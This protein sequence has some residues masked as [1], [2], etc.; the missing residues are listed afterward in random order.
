M[1]VGHIQGA[2]VYIFRKILQKIY[3][4][5]GKFNIETQTFQFEAK[6]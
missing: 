2:L 4:Y 3:F 1:L 6:S 5:F